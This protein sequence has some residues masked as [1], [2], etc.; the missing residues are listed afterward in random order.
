MFDVRIYGDPVLRK[1]AQPVTV[2][3]NDLRD[4]AEELTQTMIAKDGLGL[5]ATQVGQ[6]IQVVVVD[7]SI[8]KEPPM[9][10]VNPVIT[11]VSK[12]LVEKEEGCLS[13]P[14]IH[15]KVKRPA[16]I[17]VTAVD[18]LGAPMIFSDATEMLARVIQHEIDHLNGIM[19]IDHVSL[20]QRKLL[21]G[22]LKDLAQN[23]PTS[24]TSSDQNDM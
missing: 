24:K 14:D 18:I 19:I 21:S 22:R 17:T 23:G 9:V 3:G 16:V 7:P 4:F 11:K 13:L 5:A 6:T 12:E 10:L 2:F 8:G 1:K 15:L 20:L